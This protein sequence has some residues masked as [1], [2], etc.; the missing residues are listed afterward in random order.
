[1]YARNQRKKMTSMRGFTLIELLVV[2]AIMGILCAVVLGMVSGRKEGASEKPATTEAENCQMYRNF[3][4]NQ[5]PAH[6]IKYFTGESET[7]ILN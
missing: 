4:I 5:L 3:S 2:I 7:I 6:C 1:M